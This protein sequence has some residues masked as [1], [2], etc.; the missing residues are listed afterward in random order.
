M[1]YNGGC[2]I[3]VCF[4]GDGEYYGTPISSNMPSSYASAISASMLSRKWALNDGATTPGVLPNA[5]NYTQDF[6][7]VGA[8][9]PTD[10]VGA[11]SIYDHIN[12][13]FCHSPTGKETNA[14]IIFY[15]EQNG[16]FVP[17]TGQKLI[18]SKRSQI[19]K[20][21]AEANFIG[22]GYNRAN[23]GVHV[24]LAGVGAL[25]AGDPWQMG[26][27][28]GAW[29]IEL[30]YNQELVSYRRTQT[31]PTATEIK[32]MDGA[33]RRYVTGEATT[34]VDATFKWSDDGTLAHD[35]TLML[36]EAKNKCKP[37]VLYMPKATYFNGPFLDL[38]VTTND[39]TPIMP[40]PGVCELAIKGTCQ[41]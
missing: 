19:S 17:M 18:G 28:M 34:S 13:V 32:T 10:P 25:Q 24:S 16:S 27:L 37:L 31:A 12:A 2:L 5:I 6:W 41:P 26:E 21:Y 40:A 9:M 1:A 38:V 7:L 23:F 30:P 36:E 15:H 8:K 35:L 20:T 39:P 22:L 4:D 14:Q 11:S 33:V 3:G 29:V